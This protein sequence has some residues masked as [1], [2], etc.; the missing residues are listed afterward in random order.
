MTKAELIAKAKIH[1]AAARLGEMD[2]ECTLTVVAPGRGPSNPPVVFNRDKSKKHRA[3]AKQLRE[4]AK[5]L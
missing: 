1:E 2:G 5:N 4:L 3:I